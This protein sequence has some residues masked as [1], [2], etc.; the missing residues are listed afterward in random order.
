MKPLI[1]VTGYYVDH[2]E[3]GKEGLRGLPGQD[4]AL[5]SYDYIRSLQRA[6]ATVVLLQ[7]RKLIKLSPHLIN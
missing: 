2:S 4:M 3:I 5:F 7:L 6:G 1:G